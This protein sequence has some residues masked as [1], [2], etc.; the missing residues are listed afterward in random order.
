M[1]SNKNLEDLELCDVTLRQLQESKL[2]DIKRYSKE[3]SEK[4]DIRNRMMKKLDDLYAQIQDF[5]NEVVKNGGK[6]RA[7]VASWTT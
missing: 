3:L 5:K 2:H 4:R 6:R 7:S 1:K